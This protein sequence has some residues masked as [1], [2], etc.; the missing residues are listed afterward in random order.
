[1]DVPKGLKPAWDVLNATKESGTLKFI[2]GG[3][4]MVF[5]PAG[6]PYQTSVE[7]VEWERYTARMSEIHDGPGVV[8]GHLSKIRAG[9][10]SVFVDPR[11]PGCTL[12]MDR[13]PQA[14][15]TTTD[16][17]VAVIRALSGAMAGTPLVGTGGYWFQS[18][19]NNGARKALRAAFDVVDEVRIGIQGG[20]GYHSPGA[21][22]YG[23]VVNGEMTPRA[24]LPTPGYIKVLVRSNPGS[25]PTLYA[26]DLWSVFMIPVEYDEIIS[27]VDVRVYTSPDNDKQMFWEIIPYG[28]SSVSGLTAVCR[29]YI[30]RTSPN[31]SMRIRWTPGA[32]NL[33]TGGSFGWSSGPAPFWRPLSLDVPVDIIQ[34]GAGWD[35]FTAADIYLGG[36]SYWRSRVTAAAEFAG[37]SYE[38]LIRNSDNYGGLLR[39]GSDRATTSVTEAIRFP[40]CFPDFNYDNF[41]SKARFGRVADAVDLAFPDIP[42]IDGIVGKLRLNPNSYFH[43]YVQLDRVLRPMRDPLMGTDVYRKA[44]EAGEDI[45]GKNMLEPDPDDATSRP[46]TFAQAN[47]KANSFYDKPRSSYLATQAA[48]RKILTGA[49]EFDYVNSAIVIRDASGLVME[50]DDAYVVFAQ[51]S[52]S[53]HYM[54]PA[55]VTYLGTLP[56]IVPAATMYP[57]IW[58]KLTKAVW[59]D[60]YGAI[61][62]ASPSGESKGVSQWDAPIKSGFLKSPSTWPA[63]YWLSWA[64]GG[65]QA[66]MSLVGGI[67]TSPSGTGTYERDPRLTA[68]VIQ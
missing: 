28:T 45:R 13:A 43:A 35:G 38:A 23:N 53:L 16:N 57:P 61:S 39:V 67:L 54:T 59:N 8:S 36:P 27:F 7:H 1:M 58:D 60:T 47:S 12:L 3:V 22:N 26:D 65:T 18:A 64:A 17:L 25:N 66:G 14:R 62:V 30:H 4:P 10:R 40:V 31:G 46:V 20:Q 55:L 6:D 21:L 41:S 49:L 2:P 37:I 51:T 42:E 11:G 52:L 50:S 15:R 32:L 9:G 48:E 33:Y 56:A 19:L 29:P 5:S 68:V 44:S 24:L 34:Q 63:E